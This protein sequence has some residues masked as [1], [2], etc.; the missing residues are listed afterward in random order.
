[1]LDGAP[2]WSE[3]GMSIEHGFRVQ[4]PAYLCTDTLYNID[5]NKCSVTQP[6][7][8]GNLAGKIDVT[9]GVDEVNHIAINI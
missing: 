9:G 2:R 3:M 6:G 7:G 5:E 8:R 1:M 4:K